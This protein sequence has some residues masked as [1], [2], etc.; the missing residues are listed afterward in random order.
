MVDAWG[1]LVREQ[2]GGSLTAHI[3]GLSDDAKKENRRYWK[4]RV[5]Y[6]QRWIVE[7]IVSAFKRLFGNNVRVT[8]SKIGTQR[9]T[10]SRQVVCQDVPTCT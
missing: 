10:F 1:M 8:W 4:S 5:G 9:I 2:P 7:I 3:G 6:G